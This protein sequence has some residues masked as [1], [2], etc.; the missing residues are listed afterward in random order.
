MTSRP[1]N[2]LPFRS[3]ALALI[4]ATACAPIG[5]GRAVARET[6][7]A[8]ERTP[9][10]DI[11]D[12][13]VF[14]QYQSP[15]G[16]SIKVP[17]GWARTERPDGARFADKYNTVELAVAKADRAPN[18]AG[19]K[20]RE[21]AALQK[22]GRAVAIASVKDVKLTSGP[23]VLIS[24]ASNSDPNP[25]TNRQIRLEHDRYLMFKNGNLVTLDLSA[26]LGADNV[27]QWHLM[28]NSFRWR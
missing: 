7:V 17:E 20:Q 23:A 24:Y 19:A 26:P 13:Q 11:P 2:R 14:V 25:V 4:A 18:A 28:A 10:G 15:L 9:P 22:A 21:A 27:D 3:V 8:P 6:A 16:F 12:S 5:A 1:G